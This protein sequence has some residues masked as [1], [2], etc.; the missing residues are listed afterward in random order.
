[1]NYTH[2]CESHLVNGEHVP[3]VGHSR[4]PDWSG[5]K[6]CQ[7]CIDEYDGR[8]EVNEIKD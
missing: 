4:N 1:M 8:C 7:E 2:E 5:Y 3:A 6:L